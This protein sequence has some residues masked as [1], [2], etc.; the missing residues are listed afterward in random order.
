MW[1]EPKQKK[2]K[3]YYFNALVVGQFNKFEIV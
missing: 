1:S 2:L 3:D